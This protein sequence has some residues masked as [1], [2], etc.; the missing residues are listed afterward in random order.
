MIRAAVWRSS[1]LR[2]ALLYGFAFIFAVLLVLAFIYFTTV[3]FMDRQLDAILGSEMQELIEDY[4]RDGEAGLISNISEHVAQHPD[5]E[6]V[7]MLTR[8]PG[9]F[10]AGNLDEWPSTPFDENGFTDFLL[11]E[12]DYEKETRPA[13]AMTVSLPGQIQFLVGRDVGTRN[14]VHRLILEALLWGLGITIVLA[15]GI[16]VFVSSRVTGRLERLNKTARKIMQGELDQRVP[17]D[18]SNDDFDQLAINLNEMLDRIQ[19]LMI[20]NQE[21]SNNVAHDLRKPLT[22]LQHRLEEARDADSS[23]AA[24]ALEQATGEAEELMSTFK[25]L[26]RIARIESKSRRSAFTDVQVDEL[27]RDVGELYGPS[28]E[29]AGQVLEVA[30]ETGLTV[31]A[32]RNLLFQAVANLVDNAVKYTPSGGTIHLSAESDAD[33][34]QLAVADQ[35]P[36]IPAELREKV[37]QRFYR[38]DDSRSTPG[39]GLGLSLVRA[40]AD[41]HEA[42]IRL[43]DNSP[44]LRVELVLARSQ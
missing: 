39:N 44:G 27:L 18:G 19:A 32:D 6:W 26:L 29:E 15:L 24:R 5:G 28:A 16:G 34:V 17:I 14:H 1:S 38:V 20:T 43:T 31:Q 13:R 33:T 41:L 10:L 9:Q 22:R 7:Y 42:Q 37:F 30:A 35:G 4:E 36:G 23:E 21:I 40:I 2:I 25:A 3:G 12:W 8:G 11:D